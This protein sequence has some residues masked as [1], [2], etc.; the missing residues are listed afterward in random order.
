MTDTPSALS[1]V[2]ARR[3]I[4]AGEMSPVALLEDCIEQYE[5]VNPVVNAIVTTAF[6]R[7]R[8][9]AAKV[10][11]KI[12]DGEVVGTLAGLPVAIKD[13]QLTEGVRT[14]FGSP[15]RADL[16]PVIDA[17]IV[18]R[19]RAA[20]GIVFGKTNI[21]EFSIGANTVNPLFGATGNPFD[22][23]LTCGG[24]SGGSAVAVA[25]NMVPLATGS[26]HGG[27]LRIPACYS[28][29][30][31][32]RASPGVVPNEERVIAQTHYS[33]QGPVARTVS[34]AALLLSVIAARSGG[35]QRDPMAFP[36]NSEQFRVSDAIDLSGIR[37]AI[38]TD[39]GGVLVSQVNR[40]TFADRV[41]LMQ[42][43][44]KTCEVIDLDITSAPGVDWHLRQ[45][46][47][48]TQYSEQAQDW[49]DDFNPNVKATY[50][51]AIKT[52]MDDI[53]RARREQVALIHKM[54][55]LF[56]DYDLLITPGVSIPPFPWKDLNPRHID[57]N[58][59][60][61]YMAWLA[62]TSSLTV[63][64]NPV[65]ALPCGL[66]VQGTPFGIQVVGPIHSDHRLISLAIA[67]EQAFAEVESLSRPR[68]VMARP[69]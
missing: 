14:T 17:G 19:I 56:E 27:S 5:R 52:P 1:A 49:P 28:G 16:V 23:E 47:F 4:L 60:E 62:L 46:V 10:E 20:D 57:G 54:S 50:D 18:A 30:V 8:E 22:P 41:E 67:I 69:G 55:D 64:G 51:S 11:R 9:E 12:Q 32:Y 7:A 34:D 59:V 6:E 44:F 26:D 42:G 48:A 33:L 58:A 40:A 15:L 38:S 43:L 61:N 13:N 31:G 63:V 37:V 45:D 35:A 25:T 2:E 3:L 66:D 29:V 68:P 65:V 36:L 21:P 39:L 24:S 53:A